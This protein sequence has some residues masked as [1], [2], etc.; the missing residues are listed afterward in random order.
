MEM[1]GYQRLGEIKKCFHISTD[2]E[3]ARKIGVSP[4]N[5]TDVKRRG[6]MSKTVAT[7]ICKKWSD[8]DPMW[9]FNGTGTMMKQPPFFASLE[10]EEK[11]KEYPKDISVKYISH[12]E[13]EIERIRK[14]KEELWNLVQELI[15]R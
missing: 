2:A 13:E 9:V 8:L 11:E 14:E 4:Q 10:R 15:K 5:I 7:A 1:T 12:L 6:S 3:L